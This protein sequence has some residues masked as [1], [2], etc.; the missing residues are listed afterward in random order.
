[1]PTLFLPHRELRV[2]A[3]YFV[4][5]VLAIVTTC[6]DHGLAFIWLANA[7][8]IAILM[9]HPRRRWMRFIGWGALASALATGLTGAGWALA[10]FL[11]AANMAEVLVAA[12]LL[13]R[14]RSA[15]ICLGSM[16][17]T[18]TLLS[19]A[20]IA[21]PVAMAL[22]AMLPLWWLAGQQPADTLVRVIV[23]HGLSNMTIIPIATLYLTGGTGLWRN[24]G[25]GWTLKRD[26]PSF[27]L[28]VAITT[29][30]FLQEQVPLLFLPILPLTAI[31]FNG[32]SRRIAVAL[33]L[34][35]GIGGTFT[36]FGSGPIQSFEA[37]RGEAMQFFQFYLL[38]TV[39]T[40]VPI[41]AQLRSRNL[42]ARRVRDSEAR[43][44]M[45]AD[46]SSDL[47]AHTDLAGRAL[48]VS[49]S[50][51]RIAG[52]DAESVTGRDIFDFI[53]PAHRSRVTDAHRRAITMNGEAQRIEYRGQI[54]SGEWRWFESLCR[55]VIGD[56]GRVT[57]IVSIV[58]DI[59]D[60]KQ[61]EDELEVAALTNSL[62][63]LPNRRAFRNAATLV[64]ADQRLEESTIALFDIDHFKRVNDRFGHDLGDEVLKTFAALAQKLVRQRDVLA[65][66]GG[67]EFAI[68][69]AG[70][71]PAQATLVCERIRS[72]ISETPFIA[73]SGRVEI[74]V[75]G[76]IAPLGR[77]GLDAALRRADKALYDAKSGG[78]DRLSLAA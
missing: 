56:R 59:S 75:S 29:M 40:V 68:I 47:I 19:A 10:P 38:S 60:R 5:A 44:R 23:G 78:R 14:G 41:A 52:Y 11:A 3:A 18:L 30:V 21:G 66:I 2:A 73:A 63:G 9:R 67:E 64:M 8:L 16:R 69:F 25:Q 76:G 13:R 22:V 36:L 32:G 15:L 45:L 43:Y 33:M 42:L 62:T 55:G 46:H 35:G 53:D 49:P 48:F 77:D 57:G 7:F 39:L 50:V 17:W 20:G 28:F 34:L 37:T 12:F 74:T 58:R 51:E 70:L 4:L 26:V 71:A 65:R 24:P 31:T 27:A 1:M 6:F 61:R 54:R 72:V